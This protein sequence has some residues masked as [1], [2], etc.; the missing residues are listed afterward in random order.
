MRRPARQTPQGQR[1]GVT[2]PE[3]EKL[4]RE[5]CAVS[6]RVERIEADR[7]VRADVERLRDAIDALE[8]SVMRVVEW[9]R[10][11]VVGDPPQPQSLVPRAARAKVWEWVVVAILGVLT[12]IGA[13]LVET[14]RQSMR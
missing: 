7:V 4:W 2:E 10:D 1:R 5:L 8:R 14:C 12:G 11:S 3:A 13:V 6:R 9:E